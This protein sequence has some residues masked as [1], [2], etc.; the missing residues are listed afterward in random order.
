MKG[1]ALMPF[2]N[3]ALGAGKGVFLPRFRVKKDREISSHGAI[4]LGL[5]GFRRTA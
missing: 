5:E 4:A 3:L 1:K 2:P